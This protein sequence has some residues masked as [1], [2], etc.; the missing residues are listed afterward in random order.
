MLLQQHR[1]FHSSTSTAE[2]THL[3]SNQEQRSPSRYLGVMKIASNNTNGADTASTHNTFTRLTSVES[4]ATTSSKHECLEI[5]YKV[6]DAIL[7]ICALIVVISLFV[8]FVL[9]GLAIY[10]SLIPIQPWKTDIK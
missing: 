2:G 9:V 5:L 6:T 3:L 1:E 8:T 10:R 4:N 7:I